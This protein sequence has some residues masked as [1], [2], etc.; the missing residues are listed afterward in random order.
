[1]LF[2]DVEETSVCIAQFAER[3]QSNQIKIKC[4]NNLIFMVDLQLLH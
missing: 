4:G 2:E 3:L 1:M